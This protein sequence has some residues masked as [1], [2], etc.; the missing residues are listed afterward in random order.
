MYTS[1]V[2]K[3]LTD[4]ERIDEIEEESEKTYAI[5]FVGLF[6]RSS[7]CTDITISAIINVYVSIKINHL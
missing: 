4:T 5:I 3:S 6:G 1:L 2:K 7:F